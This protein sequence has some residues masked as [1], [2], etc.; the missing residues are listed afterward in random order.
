MDA[1]E[2]HSAPNNQPAYTVASQGIREFIARADFHRAAIRELMGL[3]P[4]G[5]A[6]LDRIIGEAV[7][8]SEDLE[9][10]FLVLAALC[11]ERP[12]QARHLAHG[13]MLVPDKYLLGVIASRMQGDMAAPLL[14]AASELR[15]PTTE[16]VSTALFLAASCQVDH[17]GKVSA[18]LVSAARIAPRNK[19][20]RS[21]ER[22]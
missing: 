9:F 19:T 12:V 16:M 4:A 21:E 20:N 1:T 11:A 5:D 3:L 14:H 17:G 8:R 22:R 18:K 2:S 10:I 15:L 6:A 13:T 7:T